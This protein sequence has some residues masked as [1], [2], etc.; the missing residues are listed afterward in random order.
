MKDAGI[1]FVEIGL[2]DPVLDFMGQA[3]P[4]S[5][6]DTVEDNDNDSQRGESSDSLMLKGEALFSL[7][8]PLKIRGMSV[9]F[10][11]ASQTNFRGSNIQA[12]ILPKLKQILFGKTTLPAGE[13]IIPFL[14]E[15]PNIYPATLS[16]KRASISYKVELS[17]IGIFGLQ[18]KSITAEHPVE[19]R[20]H[21]LRCK[22]MAPLV[23]TQIIEDTV[24]AKF[25]Y[26]IDAPQI[27]C[28]QQGSIPFSIKYLCFASQKPVRNI[29]TQLKQIELYR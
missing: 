16:I 21:L 24:P 10:K 12:S 23:E 2:V 20:R 27:V 26:E 8:R 17:I 19:I 18:K 29:R 15:V 6:V 28:L 3:K 4:P 11:G 22:E 25:H 9:K 13:H 7:T 1:K 14:L 5:S